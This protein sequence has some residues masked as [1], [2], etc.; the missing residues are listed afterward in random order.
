MKFG[1]R[2]LKLRDGIYYQ[3]RRIEDFVGVVELIVAQP[4]KAVDLV[5]ALDDRFQR[6]AAPAVVCRV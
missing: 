6:E 3:L 1:H 4:L 5:A 2:G